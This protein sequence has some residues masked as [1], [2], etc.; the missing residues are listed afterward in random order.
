M[1]RGRLL[2]TQRALLAARQPLSVSDVNRLV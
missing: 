2:E 1:G